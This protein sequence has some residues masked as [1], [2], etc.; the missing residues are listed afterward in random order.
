MKNK[1]A[2][3]I[4]EAM[5]KLELVLLLFGIEIREVKNGNES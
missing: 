2:E 3:K 5:K 1:D 4:H